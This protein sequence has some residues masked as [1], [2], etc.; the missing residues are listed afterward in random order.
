MPEDQRF[1]KLISHQN[2]QWNILA[3]MSLAPP[4]RVLAI[5]LRL[6]PGNC[7][8]QKMPRRHRLGTDLGRGDRGR[9]SQGT[10]TS[11][12]ESLECPL[13]AQSPCSSV[14][15]LPLCTSL[16][17]HRLFMYAFK[18]QQWDRHCMG[19]VDT[20]LNRMSPLGSI[21]SESNQGN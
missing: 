15:L 3:C 9:A 2:H 1:P 8:C 7:I 16:G 10:I 13:A 4:K 18:E 14:P 5:A 6:E 12:V 21:R 11:F 19:A 20:Q 17:G